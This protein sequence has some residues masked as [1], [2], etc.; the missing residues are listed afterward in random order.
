[1]TEISGRVLVFAGAGASKAVNSDSFPTT[2]EFFDE[3]LSPIT[4]DTLFQFCLEYIKSFNNDDTVDIEQVLWALQSLYEFYGNISNPK[5][6][7]GY[8]IKNNLID[9]LF[10]GHNTGHLLGISVNIRQRIGDL[11]DSINQI[12]YDLYAY[13]PSKAEL[14]NNWIELILNLNGV[15]KKLDI[16]TTNYDAVIEAALND[17]NGEATARINRGISGNV[18]QILDLSNWINSSSQTDVLLTKLHGSLD[19]KLSGDKI[20]IG[21]PVFTGYHNKQA[22]IY[23]GFKGSS[24][25]S[26]FAIFHEYLAQAISES[27][28]LIFIGFAF[29]DEY[30]NELIRENLPTNCKVYVINPDKSIKFP[31]RRSK[32]Q[33]IHGGFDLKSIE[34]IQKYLGLN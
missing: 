9:K 19:W 21:D 8:S 27:S 32:P 17:I 31:S 4:D 16:F 11:I 14:E 13:E 23:P 22:I 29:R 7:S 18:R 12:V 3:L 1:M 10:Q 6:I 34:Q 28:V 5:D 30:I 20:H 15:G 25:L 24:T 2:K 33:Y 26:F